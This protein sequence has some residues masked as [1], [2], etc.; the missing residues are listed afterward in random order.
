MNDA[1]KNLNIFKK[2]IFRQKQISV[3]HPI[4]NVIQL[5]NSENN[6]ISNEQDIDNAE[7]KP[8]IRR[9]CME[10][11]YEYPE[12]CTPQELMGEYDNG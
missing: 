5:E 1:I 8:L 10:N 9:A 7:A 6:P 12:I 4:L 2:K 11:N 3:Y